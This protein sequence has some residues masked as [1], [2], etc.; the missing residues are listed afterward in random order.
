[1]HFLV[2]HR[3][4]PAMVV[5]CIALA[6]ALGGTSVA[7]IQALPK[8][9]V[10]TRHLKKNAVTSLKVKNRSLL[11]RDFK[12]GQ[13]PR[14]PKGD[15]GDQ[16]NQ[17]NPGPP[18]AANV[19]WANI[20]GDGS[21]AAQS[22]GITVFHNSVGVW[23]VR[24]PASVWGKPILATISRLD[25]TGITGEVSASACGGLP[26]GVVCGTSNDQNTVL[27]NIASSSGVSAS[28]SFYLAVVG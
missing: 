5:A 12:A 14:G 11:A 25:G 6:V 26:E 13:L 24:F 20:R 2:K 7:A 16:G 15:K 8:N 1:M 17:G 18:G 10:G 27:V 28:R 22:G 3:P 9:S 4:S 19:R 21:I 23:F